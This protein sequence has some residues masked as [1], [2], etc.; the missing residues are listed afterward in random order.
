MRGSPRA[1]APAGPG[2]RRSRRRRSRSRSSTIRCS[3]AA[4]RTLRDVGTRVLG[5]GSRRR[6][7]RSIPSCRREPVD[8]ARRGPDALG[9]RRARSQAG[10]GLLH[11]RRRADLARG[12]HRPLAGHS[13]RRRRRTGG[14]APAGG[15]ARRSSTATTVSS[16]SNPSADGPPAARATPQSRS[17]DLRDAE[18]RT[19]YEPALTTDGRAHRGG[20]QHRPAPGRRRRRSRPAARAIGLMRTRVPLPRTRRRRPREDEQYAAYREACRGPGR[21]AR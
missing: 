11:G 14:A 10:P 2:S 12:D 4:R 17:P 19:R 7:R 5:G 16:M 13:G 21:P 20:R 8:P 15:G 18:D 1:R 3:P 9:R 6:S